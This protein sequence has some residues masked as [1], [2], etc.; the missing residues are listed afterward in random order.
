MSHCV[1]LEFTLSN[2]IN[3]LHFSLRL[4]LVLMLMSLRHR[5]RGELIVRERGKRDRALSA[6]AAV[7]HRASPRKGVC[8]CVCVCVCKIEWRP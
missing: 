8:V 7:N 6:I 2:K 4:V 3:V 1:C 5:E